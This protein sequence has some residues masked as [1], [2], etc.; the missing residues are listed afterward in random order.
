M[1]GLFVV[2]VFISLVFCLAATSQVSS[3]LVAHR[4]SHYIIPWYVFSA[5]G[6]QYAGNGSY[7]LMATAGQP[8]VG[9]MRGNNNWL[10]AGYWTSLPGLTTA[11]AP[12]QA[13]IAPAS[14]RL[15]QN[16]P[17][18]FNPTTTIGIE[19]PEKCLVQ[20][21]IFNALGQRIRLYPAESR[22]PGQWMVTWDGVDDD[23]RPMGSGIYIYRVTAFAPG[24]DDAGRTILFRQARKMLL[25]K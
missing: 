24:A 12:D 5:G 4:S 10:F 25:V 11:V 19:L 6:I 13:T 8:L 15:D 20:V 23:G 17:N 22:T 14:F 1:R 21:E 7:T 3:D 2:A 16:Y 9:G 18:P